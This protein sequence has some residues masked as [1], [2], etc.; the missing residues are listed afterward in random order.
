[1]SMKSLVLPGLVMLIRPLFGCLAVI[2]DQFW[3]P[4]NREGTEERTND[5]AESGE[6]VVNGL[7]HDHA[8][9]LCGAV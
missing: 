7:G 1:M 6:C 4:N 2:V 9:C 5:V 3:L 8:T